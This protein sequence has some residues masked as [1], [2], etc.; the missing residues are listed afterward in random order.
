MLLNHA[1]IQTFTRTPRNFIWKIKW[2]IS[3]FLPYTF[4]SISRTDNQARVSTEAGYRWCT[5]AYFASHRRLLK[6]YCNCLTF[7]SISCSECWKLHFRASRFQNFLD[8][9]NFRPP[10]RLTPPA[11][12]FIAAYYF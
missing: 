4:H 8:F 1:I 7:H 10:Y 12:A 11:L 9:K 2:F 6:H 3:V 5:V